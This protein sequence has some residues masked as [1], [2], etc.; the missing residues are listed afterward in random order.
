MTRRVE[1]SG[2]QLITYQQWDIDNRLVVITN[3]MSGQVTQ[4]FYDADGQRVKRISPQNTTLY[5]SADYEVT[6]PRRWSCRRYR[7][8]TRTSCT[9][10]SWQMP[11]VSTRRR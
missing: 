11:G 9:S 3:T 4:Y 1:M 7:R 6:D 2:T 8:H 10:Q 5:V